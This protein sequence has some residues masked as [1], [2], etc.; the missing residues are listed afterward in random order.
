MT[1]TKPVKASETPQNKKADAL[2]IPNYSL[3]LLYQL[4]NV[5]L[6]G[7][8][9]RARNRFAQIVKNRVNSLEDDRIE[10]LE[11]RCN[12]DAKGKPKKKV[13]DGEESYD[14]SDKELAAYRK[15]FDAL[16]H[17]NLVID[18]LPSTKQDL[19]LI[20]PLILD[21]KLPIGT[22]DGY[23]YE[24]ICAAFEAI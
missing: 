24:E 23:T 12:K 2:S 3:A 6:H 9:S 20:R 13:T 4:L 19:V 17:E 21:S 15:E 14:I 10:L 16:M 18:I 5:P 11:A 8:Q 7:A 1:K 22:V